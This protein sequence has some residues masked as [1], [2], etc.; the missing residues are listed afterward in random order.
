MGSPLA[1]VLANF[2]MGHYE[3]LQWS[4]GPILSQICR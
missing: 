3:K 2:L 1:H 4:Q